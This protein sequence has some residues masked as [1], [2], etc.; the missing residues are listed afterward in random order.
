MSHVCVDYS[1]QYR[2]LSKDLAGPLAALGYAEARSTDVKAL[3]R[4]A[5]RH[6][7]DGVRSLWLV[8]RSRGNNWWQELYRAEQEIQIL[9]NR[10]G[11]NHRDLHAV[12][13]SLAGVA[14]TIAGHCEGDPHLTDQLKLDDGS[15]AAFATILHHIGRTLHTLGRREKA[16]AA[17]PETVAIYRRLTAARP[18]AVEPDLARSSNYLCRVLSGTRRYAAAK[19]IAL[20]K[21]Q[22]ERR[23]DAPRTA[24]HALAASILNARTV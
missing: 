17:P 14:E 5:S 10:R 21:P 1:P 19:G 24:M 15:Q 12:A 4:S 8:L 18:D 6:L 3:A 7:R 16:L 11:A 20:F 2:T 23:P 22:A 9:F 13:V